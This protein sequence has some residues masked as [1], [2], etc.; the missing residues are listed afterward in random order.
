MGRTG[1]TFVAGVSPAVQYFGRLS[2]AGPPYERRVPNGTPGGFWASGGF[3]GTWQFTQT[4]RVFTVEHGTWRRLLG[5]QGATD[6]E[7][8]SICLSAVGPRPVV[9]SSFHDPCT[10]WALREE[11]LSNAVPKVHAQTRLPRDG[12]RRGDPREVVLGAA[13]DSSSTVATYNLLPLEMKS[14]SRARNHYSHVT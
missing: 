13:P 1:T 6:R 8:P 4:S 9:P 5:A 11:K 2:T 10:L 3:D 7:D 14:P 12:V